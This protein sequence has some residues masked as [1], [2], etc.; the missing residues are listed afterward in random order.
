MSERQTLLTVIRETAALRRELI[1]R[2][3]EEGSLTIEFSNR[4]LAAVV[5]ALSC[6]W[7]SEYVSGIEGYEEMRRMISSAS[8]AILVADCGPQIDRAIEQ[9]LGGRENPEEEADG[10]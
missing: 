4:D 6:T 7:I 3:V 10:A 9:I 1:T 2:G 8:D 5:Y